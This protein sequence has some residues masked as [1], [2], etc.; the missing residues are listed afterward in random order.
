MRFWGSAMFINKEHLG[1]GNEDSQQVVVEIAADENSE[2]HE[3]Y[4]GTGCYLQH[5]L[6]WDINR[7]HLKLVIA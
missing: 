1:Q 2:N 5:R 6:K 7:K 4:G 3:S